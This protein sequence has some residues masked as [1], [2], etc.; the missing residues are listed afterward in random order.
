MLTSRDRGIPSR[1]GGKMYDNAM[2]TNVSNT[3]ANH[4]LQSNLAQ[5]CDARI[6]TRNGDIWA[7]IGAWT[8]DQAAS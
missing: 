6:G 2:K 8:V 5:R 1:G 7:K 4:Y 3:N